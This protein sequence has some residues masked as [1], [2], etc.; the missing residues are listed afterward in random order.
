MEILVTITSGI[1]LGLLLLSPI[2]LL[3]YLNK[4]NRKYKFLS[5]LVLNVLIAA[6]ILFVF[7][8]WGH[9]SNTLLLTHYGYN[10]EGSSDTKYDEHVAPENLER[11]KEL[12]TSR[13][14]IGWPL[15][16]MMMFTF[17]SP[18]LLI[19]YLTIYLIGRFKEKWNSHS[20]HHPANA[21]SDK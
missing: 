16:A 5:Y 12:A 21:D 6:S 15:K 20:P 14:G 18:Y 19:V 8:W 11:V 10:V 2:I 4:K 7:A 3:R 9:T 13:M 17:Y 1:L